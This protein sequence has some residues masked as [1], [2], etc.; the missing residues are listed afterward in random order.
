VGGARDRS[1]WYFAYGSNL[2]PG[3]FVGR[4]KMRPLCSR[5]AR[6]PGFE[7]RFDLPIGRAQ[8]GVANVF[9]RRGA[10]VWGVAYRITPADLARLDRSEG[11]HRGFYRRIS[12]RLHGEETEFGAWTYHS[13]RGRPGRKPSRRYLGLLLRGAHYHDL[14][15]SYVA[16]LRQVELAQDERDPQ[17]ALPLSGT[18][19]A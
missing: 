15:A 2:D 3:T 18:G 8:R 9:P 11:V 7:L 10:S 6:L 4:R 5:V 13:L 17:I 14:P 1:C 19:P 16:A 12:V